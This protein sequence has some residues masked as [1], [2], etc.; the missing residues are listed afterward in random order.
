MLKNNFLNEQ[1]KKLSR[2]FDRV[3][4]KNIVLGSDGNLEAEIYGFKYVFLKE[5]NDEIPF[6][7]DDHKFGSIS[8]TDID[9]CGNIALPY[10]KYLGEKYEKAILEKKTDRAVRIHLLLP[11]DYFISNTKIFCENA[12]AHRS[13][14]IY[15]VDS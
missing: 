11:G 5:E 15:L 12:I 7:R 14:D 9:F 13:K 8:Q 2:I 4:A 3:E 10:L 6:G 1:H